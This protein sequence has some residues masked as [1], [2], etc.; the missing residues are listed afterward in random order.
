VTAAQ[1]DALAALSVAMRD[2]LTTGALSLV[3]GECFDA[4]SVGDVC[5]AIVVTSQRTIVETRERHVEW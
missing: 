1:Y 4:A 2:A 3:E 5:Q